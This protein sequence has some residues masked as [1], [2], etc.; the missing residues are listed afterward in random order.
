MKTPARLAS[1]FLAFALGL[2]GC[3]VQ[4]WTAATTDLPIKEYPPLEFSHRVASPA[5]E[6]FWNCAGGPPAG[7][8]FHG[9]A[10]NQWFAGEVRWVDLDL[11]GV[12]AQGR[13][14]S[15]GSAHEIFQIGPLRAAPFQIAMPLTGT[16]VRF[17]LYYQYQY[18]EPGDR[19][20]G[21]RHTQG[22]PVFPG[23]RLAA[24]ASV[25]RVDARNAVPPCG[26]CQQFLA[27]DVCAPGKL[28]LK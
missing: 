7:L 3:G 8:E 26:D 11:K 2:W 16:E 14:V 15:Q 19:D 9:I 24:S 18:R 5:V 12:D 27:R 20:T 13:T 21:E 1:A 6:L 10:Y 22:A 25:Q 28:R 17:D 23:F 4:P